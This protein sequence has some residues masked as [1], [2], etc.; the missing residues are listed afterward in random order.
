VQS[1]GNGI[2]A[3]FGALIAYEDR[4][5]RALYAALR[6]QDGIWSYSGKLVAEGGTPL[7]VGINTGEVAVRTLTTDDTHAEYAPIWYTANLALRVAS[8]RAVGFN[9]DSRLAVWSR[10]TF[11]PGISSP[12]KVISQEWTKFAVYLDRSG[13]TLRAGVLSA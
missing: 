7:R 9:R 2:F 13:V 3:L 1:T 5:Q 11:S 10:A 12:R 4:P 8:D 6:L